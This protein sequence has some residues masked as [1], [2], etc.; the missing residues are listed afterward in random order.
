MACDFGEKAK[1]GAWLSAFRGTSLDRAAGSNTMNSK[2]N[3]ICVIPT[4]I[5][6]FSSNKKIAF[7]LATQYP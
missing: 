7:G 3:K 6:L 2:R 5:G 4:N 1:T